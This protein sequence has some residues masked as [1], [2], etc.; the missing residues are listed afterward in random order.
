MKAILFYLEDCPYC[1]Y[2]RRA[3]R[4]LAAEGVEVPIEW[5]EESRRPDIAAKYDYWYVPTLFYGEEKLYE[6]HP[7][8]S[9]E[10]VKR[11]LRGAMDEI[12]QSTRL[13]SRK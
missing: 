12:L 3:L 7:S 1:R 13:A 6:A 8:Q 5:V 9:Y 11:S 2:A 4:E 10:D